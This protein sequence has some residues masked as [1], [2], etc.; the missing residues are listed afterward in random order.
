MFGSSSASATKP[1]ING[2]LNAKITLA[3]NALK[4]HNAMIRLSSKFNGVNAKNQSCAGDAIPII[5]EIVNNHK[6]NMDTLVLKFM[7]I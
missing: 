6:T 5:P 3:L 1:K 4:C 2:I 7:E